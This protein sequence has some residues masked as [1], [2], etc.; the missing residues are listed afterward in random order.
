MNNSP[1]KI[2]T[3]FLKCI[4]VKRASVFICGLQRPD[5]LDP[6]GASVAS[7]CEL[8]DTAAENGTLQEQYVC[9]SAEP[10]LQPQ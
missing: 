1:K 5:V 10:S 6:P 2:V 3:Q 7:T 8:P 9:L 4:I